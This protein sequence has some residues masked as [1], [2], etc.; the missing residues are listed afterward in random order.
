M[1]TF[2]SLCQISLF[3]VI[4]SVDTIIYPFALYSRMRPFSVSIICTQ[5]ILTTLELTSRKV[6]CVEL[7]NGG[8]THSPQPEASY[9]QRILIRLSC[10]CYY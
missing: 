1:Q 9:E 8:D 10:V 2:C 6:G 7:E 3:N 5:T 4:N